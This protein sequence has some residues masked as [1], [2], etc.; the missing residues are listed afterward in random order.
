MNENEFETVK[1]IESVYGK[2]KIA[3]TETGEAVIISFPRDGST[4]TINGNEH[5]TMNHA[6]EM[7]THTPYPSRAAAMIED[8]KDLSE[9]ELEYTEDITQALEIVSRFLD[10]KETADTARRVR[11]LEKTREGIARRL[12]RRKYKE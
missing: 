10:F 1:E 9:M 2:M 12:S 8:M 5:V 3:K 11:P 6:P 4:I 7:L